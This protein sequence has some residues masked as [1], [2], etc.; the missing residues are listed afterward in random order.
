MFVP[1]R[2]ISASRP[3]CEEE[4]NPRT[5]TIAAV[6]IAIP[7]F[8]GRIGEVLDAL[9]RQLDGAVLGV[10]V[11]QLEAQRG[12]RARYWRPSLDRVPERS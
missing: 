4:D 5:A 3:A 12:G 9:E 10:R 8:A 2:S 6:P 11:E 7:S 1:S